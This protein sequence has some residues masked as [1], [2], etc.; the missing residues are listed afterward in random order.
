MVKMA[1][2][3]VLA[4]IGTHC[5]TQPVC[6]AVM[7]LTW[8]PTRAFGQRVYVLF[9]LPCS[10]RFIMIR[11]CFGSFGAAAVKDTR[12][13]V[14]WVCS[15]SGQRHDLTV[16]L[17]SNRFCL[18]WRS[19]K[20]TWRTCGRMYLNGCKRHV[21]RG[22]QG[23]D[24]PCWR[25]APDMEG[26][27]NMSWVEQAPMARTPI[28]F[29]GSRSA[30]TESWHTLVIDNHYA[31][32]LGRRGCGQCNPGQAGPCRRNCPP[33]TRRASELTNV[34]HSQETCYSCSLGAIQDCQTS[35]CLHI[36]ECTASLFPR[37]SLARVARGFLILVQS[38]SYQ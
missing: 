21:S 2:M 20:S 17:H 6:G 18:E 27:E 13:L 8:F 30:V 7:H 29:Q 34:V 9:W 16:E 4:Y 14:Q 19:S 11:H 33:N 22:S 25:V 24:C 23:L 37:C 5:A 38:S 36:M 28:H 26:W 10:A 15:H 12:S 35:A 31:D 32:A 1:D 3:V